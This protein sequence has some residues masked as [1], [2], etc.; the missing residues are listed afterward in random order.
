MLDLHQSIHNPDHLLTLWTFYRGSRGFG[1]CG[2]YKRGGIMK[3][4]RFNF[5]VILEAASETF[6]TFDATTEVCYEVIANY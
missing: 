6:R 4:A 2:W 3:E 5:L 1:Y